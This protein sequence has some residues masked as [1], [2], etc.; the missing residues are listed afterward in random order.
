MGVAAFIVEQP[1]LLMKI[2]LRDSGRNEHR[3]GDVF[4]VYIQVMFSLVH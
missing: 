2:Y 3:R 4:K 1:R